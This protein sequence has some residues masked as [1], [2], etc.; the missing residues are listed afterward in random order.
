MVDRTYDTILPWGH[1]MR[2]KP[3]VL[4]TILIDE[5][6]REWDSLRDALFHGRLRFKAVSASF[7]D[8]ELER[9]LAYLLAASG[10]AGNVSPQSM[11][12]DLF[13]D[14]D[15]RFFY[16]HWL[17]AEGLISGDAHAPVHETKITEEG[18]SIAKMLL[19]TRPPQLA[20]FH[21]GVESV[22]YAQGRGEEID[23]PDFERGDQNLAG[24][25]YAFVRERIG[26]AAA[27]SLLHRDLDARM[28]LVRTIWVQTFV[29]ERSRDGCF[30]WLSRRLDRW[31][32]WGEV[33]YRTSAGAL[34][35]RLF[36]L[37]MFEMTEQPKGDGGERPHTTETPDYAVPPLLSIEYR[38][39]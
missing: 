20:M 14:N 23:R 39:C 2:V 16:P 28:P 15:F 35:Q 30:A 4:D 7:R 11:R 33:A 26:Q 24:M 34:T 32:A 12:I 31:H 21:P 8:V 22:L 19:A 9:M 38:G 29:D 17:V 5:D 3:G 6:G 36:S 25:R 13:Q 18:Y 1:W 10:L 37:L 27:I